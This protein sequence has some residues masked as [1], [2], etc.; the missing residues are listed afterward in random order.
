MPSTKSTSTKKPSTK[1]PS[2]QSTGAA[3]KPAP[4]RPKAPA[5]PP[6]VRGEAIVQRVLEATLHELAQV[7]YRG[8]RIEEVAARAEV[9][10]TT[11]YRRWPSQ[12]ELIR[13]ALRAAARD[14]RVAPN[15]GS[16]RSDLF[17]LARTFV[18]QT[19]HPLG[20]SFIRMLMAESA[21]SELFEILLSLREEHEAMQQPLI[22]NAQARGELA[23][24]VNHLI[25]FQALAGALHQR[26]FF[27]REDVDDT[28]LTNLIDLLLLGALHPSARRAL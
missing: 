21:D 10:K 13:D 9:N 26:I 1:K 11:V 8:F 22:E 17:A 20:Q 2:T 6:L 19:R 28:F 16:L 18:E 5:K 3:E 12:R 7:G 15:T 14:K 23:P 25:I 4:R 27:M 24:G